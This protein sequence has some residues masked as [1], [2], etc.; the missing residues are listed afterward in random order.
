MPLFD[1]TPS[2][3]NDAHQIAHAGFVRLQKAIMAIIV[4]PEEADH[5]PSA[6]SPAEVDSAADLLRNTTPHPD[7]VNVSLPQTGDAQLHVD[8]IVNAGCT[9]GSFRRGYEA[10]GEEDNFRSAGNHGPSKRADAMLTA[11]RNGH[12]IAVIDGIDGTNQMAAMGNRSGCAVCVF[13]YDP[14]SITRFGACIITGD[15]FA[16]RSDGRSVEFAV[17]NFTAPNADLEWR[18]LSDTHVLE[19]R[20]MD[21]PHGVMPAGKRSTMKIAQSYL[22]ADPNSNY[23]TPLGGNPGLMNALVCSGSLWGYQPEA[24]A[25][26]HIGAF[27]LAALGLSVLAGTDTEPLSPEEIGDRIL[28]SLVRGE[29]MAPMFMGKTNDLALEIQRHLCTILGL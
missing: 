13:L 4:G 12:R 7:I 5:I 6:A 15:G 22:D 25:W 8:Q 27:F 28:T 24:W 20:F 23:I 18:V 14:K 9:F 10:F 2:I 26:D 1:A 16:F 17:Y 21:R 3:T 19:T 11:L 29:K